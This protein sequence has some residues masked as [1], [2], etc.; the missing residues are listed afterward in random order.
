MTTSKVKKMS[1]SGEVRQSGFAK[2]GKVKNSKGQVITV[3]KKNKKGS[4]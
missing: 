3:S 1:T 4:C 2:V